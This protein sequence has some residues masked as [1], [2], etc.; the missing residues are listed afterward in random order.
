MAA[1]IWVCQA[2]GPTALYAAAVALERAVQ[3]ANWALSA[4][5]SASAA[6][7]RSRLRG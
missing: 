6:W 3:L 5:L 7:A 2:F 1:L 4:E